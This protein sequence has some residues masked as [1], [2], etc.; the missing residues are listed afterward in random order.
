MVNRIQ[1]L[2]AGI[3]GADSPVMSES[4]RPELA[5]PEALALIFGRFRRPPR[6]TDEVLTATAHV[7]LRALPPRRRPMVLCLRFPRVANRL[8]WV[9]SDAELSAQTF[10]DLLTDR[11]GG[12]KGFP[13]QVLAELKRLRDFQAPS[14]RPVGDAAGLQLRLN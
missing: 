13:P 2:K 3:R 14:A 4:I 8:A 12:R 6:R 1:P 11:R 5:A 9:W 7:W 10:D